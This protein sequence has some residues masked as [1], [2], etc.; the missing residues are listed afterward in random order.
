MIHT[1]V[2]DVRNYHELFVALA[3]ENAKYT[4]GN[5]EK[6]KEYSFDKVENLR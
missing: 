4:I 3:K 6:I 1:T 2:E 5:S